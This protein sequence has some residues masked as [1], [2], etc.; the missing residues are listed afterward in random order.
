MGKFLPG[1]QNRYRPQ[2]SF[3]NGIFRGLNFRLHRKT[4]TRNRYQGRS[5]LFRSLMSRF[6]LEKRLPAQYSLN[7]FDKGLETS[8][9]LDI[10]ANSDLVSFL[11]M[12]RG[13]VH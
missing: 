6:S 3:G 7:S 4:T 2:R 1:G 11:E 13:K 12:L 10:S 9:F 5:V 8:P